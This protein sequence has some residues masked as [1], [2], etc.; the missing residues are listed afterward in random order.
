MK[1]QTPRS[2]FSGVFLIKP[3]AV[4]EIPKPYYSNTSVQAGAAAPTWTGLFV[5]DALGDPP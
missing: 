2:W 5:P 1:N 4:L 3:F